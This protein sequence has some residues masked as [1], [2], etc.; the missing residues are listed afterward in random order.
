MTNVIKVAK[1]GYNVLTDADINNFIFDSSVNTFKIL[2]EGSLLSQ[3]I[4]SDPTT[5]TVAH[6]QSVNPAIYALAKFP[7][8]YLALPAQTDHIFTVYGSRHWLV[9]I[10]ATNISFVFYKG[11]T[12]LSDTGAANGSTAANDAGNGGTISWANW[13]DGLSSNNVYATATF[14]GAAI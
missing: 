9:N 7:D 5:L 14:T 11:G 3:T 4:S 8:G 12:V 10:D 1:A 2:A 13:N 6:G